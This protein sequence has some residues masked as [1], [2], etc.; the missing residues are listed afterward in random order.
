MGSKESI[1][2]TIKANQ[3]QYVEMPSVD[4]NAVIRYDDIVQQ[5]RTVLETIG[6][7]V[8]L[9]NDVQVIIEKL[10]AEKLSGGFVLNA[11]ES[12]NLLKI[13]KT[14]KIRIETV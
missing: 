2:E 3:P 9:V 5:F 6:G 4:L 11:V 13:H 8:E 7:K 1:L 10:A 12:I 14:K